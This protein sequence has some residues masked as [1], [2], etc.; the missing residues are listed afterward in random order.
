MRSHIVLSSEI[1]ADLQNRRPRDSAERLV[2]TF[3]TSCMDTKSLDEQK[4]WPLLLYIN[5][6]G[7]LPLLNSSKSYKN[8]AEAHSEWQAYNEMSG[9]NVFFFMNFVEALCFSR[10]GSGRWTSNS[11]RRSNTDA[12]QI[13]DEFGVERWNVHFVGEYRFAFSQNESK[14]L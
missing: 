10:M 12:Y 2:K 9:L 4:L 5:Q 7:G 3:Y 6:M 11:T 14:I 13:G 1:I 8:Y